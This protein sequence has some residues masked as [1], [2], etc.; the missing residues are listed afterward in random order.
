MDEAENYTGWTNWA[1]W[2]AWAYLLYRSADL[3]DK[4]IACVGVLDPDAWKT[5]AKARYADILRK[6]DDNDDP[7]YYAA[8]DQVD[9]AQLQRVIR[10]K[11]L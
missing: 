6:V 2:R 3:H 1:T 8:I 11:L 7:E 5:W 10:A 9:W 4:V